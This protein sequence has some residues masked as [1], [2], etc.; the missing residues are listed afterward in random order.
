MTKETFKFWQGIVIAIVILIFVC[1]IFLINIFSSKV[2]LEGDCS[3]E[4]LSL[5]MNETYHVENV[6]LSD[7]TLKCH[8]KGEGPLLLLLGR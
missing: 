7:G 8:F 3:V 6:S 2:S 1:L 4:G 5:K